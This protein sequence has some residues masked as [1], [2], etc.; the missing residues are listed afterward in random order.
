MDFRISLDYIVENPDYTK[1]LAN[2]LN[3]SNVSV[4]KQVFELLGALCVYNAEG[5]QR[6]LETLEHY[7]ASINGRYRFKV[8]VEELHNSTDLEYLTA[9]VAFVNCTIISAKSL[10][11]R[12]RIRNEYIG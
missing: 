6:A 8:V 5:Y 12:I 3:T 2:A 11:D 9:V 1:K 10:K 7:K 4:K